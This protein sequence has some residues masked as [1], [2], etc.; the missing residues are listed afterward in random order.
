MSDITYS[1]RSTFEK[2][3]TPPTETM[4]AQIGTEKLRTKIS[5][6][7]APRTRQNQAEAS[8][9]TGDEDEQPRAEDLIT[10]IVNP[11]EKIIFATPTPGEITE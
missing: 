1:D 8:R 3:F 11:E 7:E 2:G 9:R 10:D 6:G 5:N 4:Q